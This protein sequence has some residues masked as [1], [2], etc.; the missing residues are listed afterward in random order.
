[1][2][3]FRFG[4]NF[5]AIKKR[6]NFALFSISMGRMKNFFKNFRGESEINLSKLYLHSM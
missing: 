4:R 5:D 2:L 6:D 1:M 3:D